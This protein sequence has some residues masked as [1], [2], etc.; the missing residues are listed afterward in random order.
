MT[1]ILIVLN[2]CITA[3][4]L[5]TKLSHNLTILKFNTKLLARNRKL[6]VK[7]AHFQPL[8]LTLISSLLSTLF[9]SGFCYDTI[10]HPNSCWAL[11]L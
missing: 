6:S 7:G 5:K 10:G 4:I 3:L 8:L 1:A 2:D 11:D 9:V